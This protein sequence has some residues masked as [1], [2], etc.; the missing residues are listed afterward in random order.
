VHAK[1][2]RAPSRVREAHRPYNYDFF[3]CSRAL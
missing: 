1:A 2:V 3:V